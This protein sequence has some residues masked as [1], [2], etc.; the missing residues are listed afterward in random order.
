MSYVRPAKKYLPELQQW[1]LKCHV[2]HHNNNND[3][4]QFPLKAIIEYSIACFGFLTKYGIA[5]YSVWH[6]ISTTMWSV[7]ALL[8][9]SVDGMMWNNPAWPIEDT[10]PHDRLSHNVTTRR[11]Y[12]SL[13]EAWTLI[14]EEE[15]RLIYI[16]S[17]AWW[18][19]P[20]LQP[21][22]FTCNGMMLFHIAVFEK[23][24]N[25]F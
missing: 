8:E 1:L 9:T 25:F 6:E 10:Y 13:G 21:L 18:W 19:N 15:M 20:I 14:L 23:C 4:I 11:R 2:Q 7:K 22:I 16:L 5:R 12:L 3:K 17:W 24:E